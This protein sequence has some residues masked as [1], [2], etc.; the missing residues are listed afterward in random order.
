MIRKSWIGALALLF[1][2][3]LFAAGCG[4]GSDAG[5]EKGEVL[6]LNFPMGSRPRSIQPK[7]LMMTRW[8]W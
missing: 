6:K 4:G 8:R 7:L 5:S 3:S 1:A 2:V